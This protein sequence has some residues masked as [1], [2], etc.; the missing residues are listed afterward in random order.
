MAF[1][2]VIYKT[3]DFVV[4]FDETLESLSVSSQHPD[5]NCQVD[6][7]E[8][9]S[10]QNYFSIPYLQFLI[11]SYN[12]GCPIGYLRGDHIQLQLQCLAW[13]LHISTHQVPEPNSTTII[14]SLGLTKLTLDGYGVKRLFVSFRRTLR[15]H[16]FWLTVVQAKVRL[17]SFIYTP[18]IPLQ[19][20]DRQ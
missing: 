8:L 19:A 13:D 10:F 2:C 18:Y 3:T 11:Y 6:S 9:L 5:L 7:T 15:F 20:I 1:G 17:I 14:S 12:I 4:R 16:P